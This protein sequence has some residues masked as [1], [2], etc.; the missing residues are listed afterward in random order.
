MLWATCQGG[1]AELVRC[2][3]ILVD[4][5]SE[6]EGLG[7]VKTPRTWMCKRSK[8]MLRLSLGTWIPQHEHM[9]VGTAAWLQ[10][11]ER[12]TAC[13]DGW[14]LRE[15]ESA[16]WR[17]HVSGATVKVRGKRVP[18][19]QMTSICLGAKHGC[20]P[21]SW[22]PAGKLPPGVLT[23][24]GEEPFNNT[25]CNE[26]LRSSCEP[27]TK[28]HTASGCLNKIWHMPHSLM[29]AHDKWSGNLITHAALWWLM[30]TFKY[31]SIYSSCASL[32]HI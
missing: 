28:T 11:A 22:Y 20:Q 21:S 2:S 15:R 6:L 19:L 30:H 7:Y 10:P 9:Y 5:Y 18:S 3:S 8:H 4:F 32:F 12:W 29:P 16:G 25:N 24:G 14:G 13:W 27:S 1:S 17:S 31:I 23:A 26:R